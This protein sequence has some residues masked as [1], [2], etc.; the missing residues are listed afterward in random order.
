[1]PAFIHTHTHTHTHFAPEIDTSLTEFTCILS[2]NYFI[3]MNLDEM[4]T[5]LYFGVALF[6]QTSPLRRPVFVESFTASCLFLF[7]HTEFKFVFTF[8][9]SSLIAVV[10]TFYLISHFYWRLTTSNF[11]YV[12]TLW[13]SDVQWDGQRVPFLYVCVLSLIHI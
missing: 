9:Y 10:I 4:C 11:Y 3:I 13:K 8:F 5:F 1:M 2:S 6:L 7:S 12:L